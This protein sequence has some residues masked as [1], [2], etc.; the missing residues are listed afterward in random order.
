VTGKQEELIFLPILSSHTAL[1]DLRG[2]S[3]QWVL[4]LRLYC[5]MQNDIESFI[6]TSFSE[7]DG[8]F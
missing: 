3:G 8:K 5:K 2:R 4:S 7:M 6:V 1:I